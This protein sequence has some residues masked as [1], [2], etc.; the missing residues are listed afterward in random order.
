MKTFKVKGIVIKETVYKETDKIIILMTDKFGK[1]S[2]MAKGAK[3]NSSPI[4]ATSQFLVYSEFLLYKG[5]SFYHINSAEMLESFY[6][7]KVDYEKLDKAYEITKALNSIAYE[8][9]DSEDILSLYLNTLF[10]IANK[11][12]DFKFISS[13]FKLKAMCLAGYSPHVYKCNKCNEIMATKDKILEAYFD[14]T[15]NRIECGDCHEKSKSEN[16]NNAKRYRKISDSVL[17][18]LLY[19]ISSPVKKVFNFELKEKE[20][21]EFEDF[22]NIYFLDKGQ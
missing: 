8:N 20:L 4:L 7:I 5:T 18:A 15:N 22:V 2:C 10:V 16:I 17:I 9:E 14:K 1:I 21:R 19:T 3:K 11:D 6:S 13:I 12:K